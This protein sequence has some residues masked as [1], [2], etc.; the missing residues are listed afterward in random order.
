MTGAEAIA[1][2]E[3][4]R[5]DPVRWAQGAITI[6][7]Q[8]DES[9]I[10]RFENFSVANGPGLRVALTTN[11]PEPAEDATEDEVIDPVE[12]IRTNGLDLGALLGTTGNQNYA[13]PPE[14]DISQYDNVVIYSPTL[15]MI[16]SVAPLTM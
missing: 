14:I 16:Y 7:Q 5:L 15:E 8:V 11:I 2:G 10:L 9:K 12:N 6:Y 13:I 1:T 4:T 3:F